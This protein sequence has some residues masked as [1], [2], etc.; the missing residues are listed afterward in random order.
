M[1]NRLTH[2]GVPVQL[3]SNRS[4]VQIQVSLTGKTVLSLLPHEVGCCVKFTQSASVQGGPLEK[5]WILCSLQYFSHK[6]AQ[7]HCLIS[8]WTSENIYDSPRSE[9]LGF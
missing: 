9:V 6:L 2:P 5:M 1:L 4:I 3:F 7:R 8:L